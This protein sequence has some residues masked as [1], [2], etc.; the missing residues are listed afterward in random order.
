[1]PIVIV[2]LFNGFLFGLDYSNINFK[3]C[4]KSSLKIYK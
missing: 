3:V 2:L 1:M 4:L